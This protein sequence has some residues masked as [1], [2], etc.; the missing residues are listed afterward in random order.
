MGSL[1]FDSIFSFLSINIEIIQKI[2]AFEANNLPFGINSG[3]DTHLY[4]LLWK[5]KC[6]GGARFA[7]V[8][9]WSSCEI[10]DYFVPVYWG[11]GGHVGANNHERTGAR[12]A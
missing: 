3:A 2:T 4:L 11:Y 12:L 7:I 10:S 8:N 9:F 5:H 6:G 1:G